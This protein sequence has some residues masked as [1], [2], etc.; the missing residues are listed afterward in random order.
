MEAANLQDCKE[1][2]YY[3][4]KILGRQLQ[5]DLDNRKG[6]DY[7]DIVKTWTTSVYNRNTVCHNDITPF[8]NT[9]LSN[10]TDSSISPDFF[11][12]K[13]PVLTES[14]ISSDSGDSVK[15]FSP[16][17]DDA[18]LKLLFDSVANS[19]LEANDI[20]FHWSNLFIFAIMGLILL[21]L[22]YQIRR[23]SIK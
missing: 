7:V 19:F 15:C 8:D 17:Y 21:L 10:S 23:L 22:I 16:V 9:N 5:L 11:R 14:T 6:S 20:T 12:N 18:E 1:A 3:Y 2:E 13:A 4:M